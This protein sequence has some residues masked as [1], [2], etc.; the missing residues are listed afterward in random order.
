DQ[1]VVHL[2]LVTGDA[3]GNHHAFFRSLV[4]QHGAAHHVADG[5]HARHAGGAEV[6]DEDEAALVQGHAAVSGQQIGGHRT[7]AHGHDQLVEGQLL[8]ATGVAEGHDNLLALDL[9]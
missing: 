2:G 1:V 6:I 7:T 8:F 5:V 4:G 3:L 9:G